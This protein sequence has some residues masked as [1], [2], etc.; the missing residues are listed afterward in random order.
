[1]LSFVILA[2]GKNNM[3]HTLHQYKVIEGN[4]KSFT[5]I[6]WCCLFSYFISELWGDGLWACPQLSSYSWLG[7]EYNM[8]CCWQNYTSNFMGKADVC[9]LYYWLASVPVGH[10][11]GALAIICL[12]V[13]LT[14][15]H[16]A[17]GMLCQDDM[18]TG[19][20]LVVQCACQLFFGLG[21]STHVC[22][23]SIT[24]HYIIMWHGSHAWCWF[25]T[26]KALVEAEV[27]WWHYSNSRGHSSFVDHC[28]T[29]SVFMIW[30]AK[31]PVLRQKC[32]INTGWVCT[33]SVA[34]KK[35]HHQ[36][37]GKKTFLEKK[38]IG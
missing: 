36:T 2:D 37:I 6:S 29:F 30:L 3:M 8:Y 18:A 35:S 9:E 28:Q 14:W 27:L 32:F 1:M 12:W 15:L 33:S 24:D 21:T 23:W 22:S 26:I 16:Y 7:C 31:K 34:S 17:Y 38:P 11:A 5:R 19:E 20:F 4:T 25:W 10:P 13:L